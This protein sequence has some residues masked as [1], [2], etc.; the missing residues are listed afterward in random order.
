MDERKR[1]HKLRF[2]TSAIHAGQPPDPTTGAIIVP[3]YLTSTYVQEA[4][5][6]HKGYDYSRTANPTRT[7]LEK[8]LAVLEEG[9]FGLA[10]SSGMGATN[11]VMNLL[12]TGDHVVSSN[13]IYGGTYRLFTKLYKNYGISFSFID[14]SSLNNISKA[15][16]N[17][18]R[19]VWI[20][21]PTNPLLKIVDIAKTAEIAHRYNSLLA[22]DNTFATP[23]LQKP[24][25]L[26]ADIV[27]HSTTKYLGGH[28]DVIGGAIVVKDEELKEKLS[29][30]QNAVGAIPGAFD[31]WLVLRGIKTLGLRMER[32]S[33]NA[34][35]IA[36]YL[37][38]HNKVE[39]VYYPGLSSHPNHSL[40][41]R[42]MKLFGGM[43]SFEIY[44]GIEKANRFV[45][46]TKI[47]SLAES[48]GGVESL[49]E[50]PAIMT[51]ASI[52][53][54]ERLKAGLSDSL[55]RLS[56]GIEHIDDLIEDL[57]QALKKV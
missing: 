8:N 16:R 2:E 25:S 57:E 41:K 24:L 27:V 56:V 51:H 1:L 50:H 32:H 4:P 12:K 36:N 49:I 5:G 48:L 7:A 33:S 31:A 19:L 15:M 37:F 38:K 44:G 9:N 17:N 11:T 53:K 22:V 45:S 23:Y 39:K 3:V 55:I 30:Y 35:G 6:K 34:L 52:P 47:F 43:V 14:A 13:D 54:N 42:Q 46:I 21:T 29:F 10:F 28:S 40:A 18:T 20:E 26:G